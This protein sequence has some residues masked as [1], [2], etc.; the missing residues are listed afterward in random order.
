MFLGMTP[1]TPSRERVDELLSEL[2]DLTVTTQEAA[3]IRGVSP[4]S[5]TQAVWRGRLV[6]IRL[7][8]ERRFL[9]DDVVGDQET[10]SC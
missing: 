8:A 5:I 7:T 9:R 1:S 4:R 6:P 10:G 2:D 3:D